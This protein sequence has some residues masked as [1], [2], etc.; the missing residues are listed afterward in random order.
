[1]TLS[2]S[3]ATGTEYLPA[4]LAFKPILKNN[5][6]TIRI[7]EGHYLYQDRISVLSDKKAVN[8]KFLNKPI[9]KKFPNQGTYIV[10]LGKAQ[11]QIP[12]DIKQPVTVKYQGCSSQGLCYPPQQVSLNSN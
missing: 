3:F 4:N 6:I 1:M 2:G 5:I 9:V 12:S 8:F 11:L 10:Y 7:A